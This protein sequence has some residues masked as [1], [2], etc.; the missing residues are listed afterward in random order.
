[1]HNCKDADFLPGVTLFQY[2]VCLKRKC[3][4]K[5]TTEYDDTSVLFLPMSGWNFGYTG[6]GNTTEIGSFNIVRS[7]LSVFN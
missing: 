4:N 5:L 1:M 6:G 2:A 3:L 7:L